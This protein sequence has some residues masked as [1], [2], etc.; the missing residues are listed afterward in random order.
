LNFSEREIK[1]CYQLIAA[2]MHMGR[3]YLWSI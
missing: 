1:E 3:L 2:M